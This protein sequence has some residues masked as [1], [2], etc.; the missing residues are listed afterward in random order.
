MDVPLSGR[1]HR[2]LRIGADDGDRAAGDL[3]QVSPGAG[4]RAAG[5]DTGDEMGDA[6]LGIPPDLGAGGPVV[7]LRTVRVRVLVRHVAAGDRVGEP[8]GDRIIR[9]R[10]LGIQTAGCDDDLSAVRAEHVAFILRDLVLHDGD[11]PVA[12]LLGDQGQADAGVAA[13]RLHDDAAG[14]ELAGTFRGVDDA[15]GD[16]VLGRAAGVQVFDLDRDGGADAGGDAVE[17]DERGVADQIGD[18]GVDG[19][20]DAAF[21]ELLTVAESK[22]GGMDDTTADCGP[23]QRQ[24]QQRMIMLRA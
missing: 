15:F 11:H 5:A 14:F 19:H 16:A 7:A 12:A 10:I 1:E 13:G 2:P 17:T 21:C 9:F 22:S 3:L 18:T 6:P 23:I 8:A 4:D 24:Q 20:G